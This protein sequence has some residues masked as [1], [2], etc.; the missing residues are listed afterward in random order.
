MARLLL[1]NQAERTHEYAD[2]GKRGPG[3][4]VANVKMLPIPIPITNWGMESLVVVVEWC[5][6]SVAGGALGKKK[7]KNFK[8][9]TLF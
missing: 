5:F 6:Q 2:E 3:E 9:I 8:N 1:S 7:M 4:N